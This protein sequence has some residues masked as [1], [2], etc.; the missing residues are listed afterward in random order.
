[1]AV[2]TAGSTGMAGPGAT[3]RAD[4]SAA[5]AADRLAGYLAARRRGTDW[6]LARVNPDGS[7]G[8]VSLGYKYYRAPWA[9]AATGEVVAAHATAALDPGATS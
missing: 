6:L 8:D 9:F 3:T 4:G 7:I 5:A 1:M 2:E